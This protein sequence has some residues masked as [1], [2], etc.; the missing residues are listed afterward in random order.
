MPLA[1]IPNTAADTK[2][3][4]KSHNTAIFMKH[5]YIF[6]EIWAY[7][8]SVTKRHHACNEKWSL[9]VF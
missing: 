8:P 3:A 9:I 1:A 7:Q 5:F 2:E 4:Q 6:S